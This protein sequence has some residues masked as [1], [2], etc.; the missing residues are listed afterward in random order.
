MSYEFLTPWLALNQ[1]N[2]KKFYLLQGKPARDAFMKK[3]LLDNIATLAKSLGCDLPVPVTC[4]AKI[5]FTKD[6]IN[7]TNVIVFSGKFQA[8]IRIPDYLGIGQSVSVG[9]GT[10]KAIPADPILTAA[11]S[12]NSVS[13]PGETFHSGKSWDASSAGPGSFFLTP[14]NSSGSICSPCGLSPLPMQ[15]P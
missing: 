15:L 5:R 6:R 14:Q 8:T 9:F 3:I 7:T 1:Q 4:E 11:G 13:G 10:I 12:H 2:A